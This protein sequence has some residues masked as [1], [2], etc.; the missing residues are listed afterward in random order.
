MQK[1]KNF[2]KKGCNAVITIILDLFELQFT[3]ITC[4]EIGGKYAQPRK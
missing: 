4:V 2:L 1:I 3:C